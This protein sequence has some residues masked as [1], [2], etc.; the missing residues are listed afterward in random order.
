MESGLPRFPPGFTCPVVLR[1]LLCRCSISPTGL[2]PS[3]VHHSRQVRLS[4]HGSRMEALQPQGTEVPWFGLFPVRSPLLRESRL[5]SLPLGTE[6]FHFPRFA[7]HSLCI[8]LRVTGLLPP[9][10]PI[11]TSPDQSL[12]VSSPKHFADRPRPSSPSNAKAFPV[13]P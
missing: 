11:R 10:F 9:G 7:P 12:L 13:R 1:Y 2:S 5:I 8:Q 3:T 4:N 6:M